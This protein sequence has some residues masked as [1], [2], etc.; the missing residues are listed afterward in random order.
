MSKI[1]IPKSVRQAQQDKM[2][3]IKERDQS[4][5]DR[6]DALAAKQAAEAKCA[7]VEA[8]WET[9]ATQYGCTPKEIGDKLASAWETI[10]QRE[11][12]IAIAKM[13]LQA[14]KDGLAQYESR[15]QEQTANLQAK[16]DQNQAE[17]A[18]IELLQNALQ[19]WE[20]QL[21]KQAEERSMKALQ[22]RLANKSED[23]DKLWRQNKILRMEVERAALEC[24]REKGKVMHLEQALIL[25]CKRFGVTVQL[26]VF[27][28]KPMFVAQGFAVPVP[29]AGMVIEFLDEEITVAPGDFGVVGEE[30][31]QDGMVYVAFDLFAEVINNKFC[32]VRWRVGLHEQKLTLFARGLYKVTEVP[33]LQEAAPAENPNATDESPIPQEVPMVQQNQPVNAPNEASPAQPANHG[34]E[35]LQELKQAIQSVRFDSVAMVQSENLH[36]P[37]CKVLDRVAVPTTKA[38]NGG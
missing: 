6:D 2:V 17:L 33:L 35:A 18:K 26:D 37:L 1:N 23:G 19:E 36:D 5:K 25:L 8:R 24:Q 38:S 27:K 30:H 4:H 20:N 15:L 29:V 7:E 32:P 21:A 13:E 9:L 28:G 12:E 22:R 16:H 10:L 11:A 14:E 3:A 31:L 34:S